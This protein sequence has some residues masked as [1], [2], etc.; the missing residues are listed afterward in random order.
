[1]MRKSTSLVWKAKVLPLHNARPVNSFTISYLYWRQVE[2]IEWLSLRTSAR[3][4]PAQSR[5]RKLKLSSFQSEHR[6]STGPDVR[7][8]HNECLSCGLSVN[9]LRLRRR[10]LS[11]ALRNLTLDYTELHTSSGHDCALA[12]QSVHSSKGTPTEAFECGGQIQTRSRQ[13]SHSIVTNSLINGLSWRAYI[14]LLDS[15]ARRLKASYRYT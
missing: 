11:C 9:S 8:S 15:V 13:R 5:Y 3:V 10:L 4:L 12:V 1:M 2:R 6:L 7:C 14:P